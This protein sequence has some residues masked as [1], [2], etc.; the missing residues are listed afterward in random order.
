MFTISPLLKC[1]SIFLYPPTHVHKLYFW[2][3][4]VF[5]LSVSMVERGW[6]GGGE[7]WGGEGGGGGKG[8]SNKQCLLT[9]LFA[10][11]FSH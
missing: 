7:G 8:V 9:L 4:T 1:R 3:Y 2:E 10:V 11:I 5:I 6:G